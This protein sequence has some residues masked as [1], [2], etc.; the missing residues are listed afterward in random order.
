MNLLYFTKFFKGW[1]DDHRIAIIG[2]DNMS[3]YS[4]RAQHCV[5]NDVIETYTML[6]TI[7]S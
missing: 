7:N 6:H 4:R 5:V 3:Y 1:E 2:A